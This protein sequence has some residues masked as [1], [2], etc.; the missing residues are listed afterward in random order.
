VARVP[1]HKVNYV[2]AGVFAA[3]AVWTLTELVI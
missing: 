3:L 2:G 1:I